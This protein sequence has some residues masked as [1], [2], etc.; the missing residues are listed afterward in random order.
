MSP[1]LTP[2]GSVRSAADLNQDIRALW[3]RAG[4]HL[5]AEQRREYQAL[6]TR[7]AAAVQTERQ[8]V[9]GHDETA[10]APRGSEGRR[11]LAA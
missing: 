8:A 7:W 6:V 9:P 11:G 1:E 5:T 4:G 10:P 3:Q 2:R